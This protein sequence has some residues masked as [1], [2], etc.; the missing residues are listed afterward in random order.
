MV[1]RKQ[2]NT[3]TFFRV[4]TRLMF[5]WVAHFQSPLSFLYQNQEASKLLTI[6]SLYNENI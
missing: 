5:T 1:G 6:K 3:F 2:P 4:K